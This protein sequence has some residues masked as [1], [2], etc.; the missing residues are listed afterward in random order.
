VYVNVRYVSVKKL[1]ESNGTGFILDTAP[2]IQI[3]TDINR[4]TISIVILDDNP[5]DGQIW[6]K[7]AGVSVNQFI[8]IK[9]R[10]LNLLFV[11]PLLLCQCRSFGPVI[12]MREKPTVSA[13]YVCLSYTSQMFLRQ[14][15]MCFLLS[16]AGLCKTPAVSGWVEFFLQYLRLSYL[17]YV[18]SVAAVLLINVA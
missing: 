16:L 18:P 17:Q 6:P 5:G 2:P 11:N 14:F 13:K 8:Y 3:R 12:Y 1:I 10:L 9:N 7:Y 15:I 4:G